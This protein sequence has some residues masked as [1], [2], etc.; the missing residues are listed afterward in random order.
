[1]SFHY[2]VCPKKGG[3]FTSRPDSQGT[4]TTE[5]FVALI[6]RRSGHPE[7][8]VADVLRHA[9]QAYIDLAQETKRVEPL[10]GFLG[11]MPTSGGSHAT[12][13]FPGTLENIHPSL[14]LYPGKEGAA[15]LAHN[16]TALRTGVEGLKT[17]LVTRV[18]NKS[19]GAY[20]QYLSQKGLL[21]EGLDLSVKL[22]DPRSGVF[23]RA[24]AD[25]QIVRVADG[26]VLINEPKTLLVLPPPGLTGGQVLLVTTVV[27]QAYRTFTYGVILTESAS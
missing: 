2:I 18:T 5:Q 19:N 15:R 8:L 7:A 1:M 21:I 17:A 3:G 11:M 12:P 22:G 26:D 13:D 16:F 10:W 25:G 27:K 9:A 24:V 4:L 6:M 14:T 23:F 20:D